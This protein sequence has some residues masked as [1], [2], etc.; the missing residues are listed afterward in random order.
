MTP[1]LL[2]VLA[3]LSLVASGTFAYLAYRVWRKKQVDEEGEGPPPEG[4]TPGALVQAEAPASP[5]PSPRE[6]EGPAAAPSPASP[7]PLPAPAGPARPA[8]THEHAIPVATLLRDEFTGGL[9]VR[10]GDREYRSSAELLASTDRQRMEY[11]AADLSRWL[12]TEKPPAPRP[13]PPEPP[14]KRAAPRRPTSMVEQINAILER[15]LLERPGLTR[16]V[17]LAEGPGGAIKVY[18]G[19]DSYNAIDDV[20]EAEI[21]Q[22]IRDAVVE[23]EAGE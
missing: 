5:E 15:K 1:E 14:A 23:W 6:S 11:T 4:E 13:T 17:R 9:I 8:P 2:L 18:I 3:F 16:G 21:R 10:V 12:G 7:A 19:I 22:L 20:P